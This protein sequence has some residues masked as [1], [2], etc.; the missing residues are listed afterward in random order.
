M[1]EARINGSS[2]RSISVMSGSPSR[3][4]HHLH[5]SFLIE[6]VVR[7]VGYRGN[8][9][10]I[11]LPLQSLLHDLHMEQPQEAAPEPKAERDRRLRLEGEGGIVQL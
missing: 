9:V 3:V 10:H 7:H 1:I 5:I 2:M 11:E 6:H 4:V 8:H